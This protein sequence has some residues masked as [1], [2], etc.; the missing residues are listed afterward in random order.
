MREVRGAIPPRCYFA[1][2]FFHKVFNAVY[3][4][5]KDADSTKWVR[6]RMLR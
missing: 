3:I 5:Y 6:I 2:R 1:K 4:G